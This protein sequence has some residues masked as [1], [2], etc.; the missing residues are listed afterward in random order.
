MSKFEII[1][2]SWNYSTLLAAFDEI[3]A[4]NILFLRGV[5]KQ[6]V[7]NSENQSRSKICLIENNAFCETGK[8]RIENVKQ[9]TLCGNGSSWRI[10]PCATA[11]ANFDRKR[12]QNKWFFE[13]SKKIKKFQKWPKL[14]IFKKRYERN[15][16]TSHSKSGKKRQFLEWNLSDFGSSGSTASRFVSSPN[17]GTEFEIFGGGSKK[18]SH[19]L[20]SII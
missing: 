5:K 20:Y 19:I 18:F 17:R 16:A 8:D 14:V 7:K 2:R 15:T 11:L 9:K 1:W 3:K 6:N 12:A 10:S 4:Q 13:G